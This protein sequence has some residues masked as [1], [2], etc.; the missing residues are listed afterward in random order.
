MEHINIAQDFYNVIVSAKKL[1]VFEETPAV[2]VFAPIDGSKTTALGNPEAY[3][4]PGALYFTPDLIPGNTIPIGSGNIL[5]ITW[6]PDGEKLVNGRKIV[7]ANI[8]MS[9]GIIHFID[10]VC[11][12]QS[13]FGGHHT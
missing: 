9:N 8:P 6:A 10:G 3:I 4:L 12:S 2:T 1:S 13:S 11:I 5:N 7:E